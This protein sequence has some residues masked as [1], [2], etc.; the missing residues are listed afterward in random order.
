LISVR[1]I[2]SKINKSVLLSIGIQENFYLDVV[3]N[4]DFSLVKLDML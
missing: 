2:C 3:L 1:F 4:Q